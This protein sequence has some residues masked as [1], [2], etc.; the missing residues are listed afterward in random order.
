MTIEQYREK[1][2]PDFKAH[3]NQAWFVAFIQTLKDSHPQ[4]R[5]M[6]ETPGNRIAGAVAFLHEIKGYDTALNNIA[7]ISVDEVKIPDEPPST[8]TDPEM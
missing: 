1:Y 3:E 5:I 6:E 4:K 8:Y 7:A 2:R